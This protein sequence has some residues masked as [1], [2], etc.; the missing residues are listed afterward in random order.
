[1]SILDT[2]SVHKEASRS[3][4]E[5]FFFFSLYFAAKND[6]KDQLQTENIYM[7]CSGVNHD[8]HRMLFE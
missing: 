1:M 3:P 2:R 4:W 6:E 5:V 7:G 8:E